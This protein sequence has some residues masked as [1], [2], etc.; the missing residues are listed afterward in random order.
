MGARPAKPRPP[1]RVC[2]PARSPRA[3]GA[4]GLHEGSDLREGCAR[5]PVA[6]HHGGRPRGEGRDPRNGPRPTQGGWGDA[7]RGPQNARHGAGHQSRPRRGLDA[8]PHGHACDHARSDLRRLR[9]LELGRLL[10]QVDPQVAVPPA[11]LGQHGEEAHRIQVVRDQGLQDLELAAY[12]HRVSDQL[13]ELLEALHAVELQ[14]QGLL[15]VL[16][17][18]KLQ[19]V[20]MNADA[21]GVVDVPPE[22]VRQQVQLIA[23]TH[24]G[25][26]LEVEIR[27]E[28]LALSNVKDV[29][30][31][32]DVQLVELHP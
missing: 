17:V 10:A 1:E 29:L 30:D 14:V 13:D 22:R 18:I 3:V 16:E 11:L 24:H 32:K 31:A 4:P 26:I 6:R 20:K 28:R 25:P 7:D 19:V 9:E 23:Q 5:R 8:R 27:E 15:E 2:P 12:D 21:F